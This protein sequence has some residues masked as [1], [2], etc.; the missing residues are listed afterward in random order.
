MEYPPCFDSEE[1]FE[2]YVDLLRDTEEDEKN[3]CLDC[4]P[5]YRHAMISLG[6]CIRPKAI[7][8][9][10]ANEDDDQEES[11]KGRPR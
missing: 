7:F 4:N 1:Q 5:D 6:R 11:W 3:F 9:C 2:L 8:V 10:E